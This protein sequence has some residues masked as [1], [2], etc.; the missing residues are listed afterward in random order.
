MSPY[1]SY[2]G[3]FACLQCA[4]S[5]S[6]HYWNTSSQR[7][8]IALN[9]S[10]PSWVGTTVYFGLGMA[11]LISHEAFLKFLA[12]SKCEKYNFFYLI[13]FS[14]SQNT[15]SCPVK[16]GISKNN[17]H[18]RKEKVSLSKKISS[19]VCALI[20][21]SVRGIQK[22]A[23]ENKTRPP[24]TSFMNTGRTRELHTRTLTSG[25]CRAIAALSF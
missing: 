20:A 17:Y 22:R 2:R 4:M 3:L 5:P 10:D 16:G 13:K 19:G 11:I 14:C 25:G 24:K 23:R 21:C 6:F 12:V 15:I 7:R 1:S 8:D 9:F 18:K